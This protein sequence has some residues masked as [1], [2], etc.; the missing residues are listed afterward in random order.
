MP[1]PVPLYFCWQGDGFAPLP[2]HAKECDAR[3]V[4]GAVY[5]LEEIQ[6]R[7]AASHKQFFAAV[8]E[9][10][11]NLPDEA[12]ERFPTPDALRKFAL[13]KTGYRD[14]RSIQCA[15][16]PE[17]LRVAAFIR[18]MDEFA[19]VTVTGATVTVFTAKSQSMKAM[20]KVEF[21]HSKTSVL[22]YIADML[23]TETRALESAAAAA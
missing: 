16:R 9:G 18:P 4:V 22:D 7:S 10:W 15:S 23:G 21:Q 3:Y 19:V 20:G 1:A 12:A 11:K 5:A 17:A 8:N 2:R 14:E 13:I 6:E